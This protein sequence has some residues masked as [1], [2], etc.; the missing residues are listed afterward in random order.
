MS[1]HC[2]LIKMTER[3]KKRQITTQ[4]LLEM[5]N[6]KYWYIIGWKREYR[7]ATLENSLEHAYKVK[8]AQLYNIAK[9]FLSI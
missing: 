8:H 1:Y 4:V 6:N 2:S 7:T 5:G 3:K 9:L